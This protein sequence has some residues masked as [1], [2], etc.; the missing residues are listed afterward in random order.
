MEG[1]SGTW[2]QNK[3]ANKSCSDIEE[4]GYF[5]VEEEDDTKTR[6]SETK[7]EESKIQEKATSDINLRWN[8]DKKSSFCGGYGKE[9]KSSSQRLRKLA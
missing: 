7:A 3:N 1:K 4:E 6:E 8:R 9:S 2:Y 5:D